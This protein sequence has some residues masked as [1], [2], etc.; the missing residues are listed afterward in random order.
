MKKGVIF[1]IIM[2]TSGDMV[3]KISKNVSFFVFFADNNKTLVIV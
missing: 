1:L 2:F 3:I